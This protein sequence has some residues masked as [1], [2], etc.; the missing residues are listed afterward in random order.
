M[1]NAYTY[2]PPGPIETQAAWAAQTETSNKDR[3]IIPPPLWAAGSFFA[4][5]Q[6]SSAT[7]MK[8]NRGRSVPGSLEETETDYQR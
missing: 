2:P 5:L 7:E 3:F 6:K 8:E 1:Q 4:G